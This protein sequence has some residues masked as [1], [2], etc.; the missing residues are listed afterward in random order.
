MPRAGEQQSARRVFANMSTQDRPESIAAVQG[1]SA[2][3]RVLRAVVEPGFGAGSAVLIV[4]T[5]VEGVT[6]KRTHPMPLQGI[7]VPVPAGATQVTFTAWQPCV[8]LA[9]LSPGAPLLEYVWDSVALAPA[10][11]IVV[12]QPPPFTRGVF[13]SVYGA[14]ALVGGLPVAGGTLRAPF[15]V[16]GPLSLSAPNAESFFTLQWE[17]VS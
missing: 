4:E 12:A 3:A 11:G 17:I 1:Q 6:T 13:V 5:T 7:A 16:T 2:V 9:A 10:S 8:C 14:N 15:R